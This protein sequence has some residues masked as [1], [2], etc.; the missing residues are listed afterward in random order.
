[1]NWMQLYIEMGLDGHGE[2][3]RRGQE[4][5]LHVLEASNLAREG[6]R[7]RFALLKSLRILAFCLQCGCYQPEF[8][9]QF[10]L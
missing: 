5:S 2:G 10:I 7:N 3:C 9:E 8:S 1:M 6:K 4:S